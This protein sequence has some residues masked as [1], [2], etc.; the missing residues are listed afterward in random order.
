MYTIKVENETTF[1]ILEA[2]FDTYEEA[3]ARQISPTSPLVTIS[4]SACTVRM[5]K[6][7][8]GK[9]GE[10]PAYFFAFTL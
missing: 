9:Q 10:I 6:L 3:G 5:E 4:K 2:P 7:R 8:N 1:E